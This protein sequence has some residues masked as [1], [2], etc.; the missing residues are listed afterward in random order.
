MHAKQGV[1]RGLFDTA[2]FVSLRVNHKRANVLEMLDDAQDGVAVPVSY[3]SPERGRD[4][5]PLTQEAVFAHVCL[6]AAF[7]TECRKLQTQRRTMESD[8]ND[9]QTLQVQQL[10][11]DVAANLNG[12][13]E[14]MSQQ[15][16]LIASLQASVRTMRARAI[17]SFARLCSVNRRVGWLTRPDIDP[18]WLPDFRTVAE[19]IAGGSSDALVWKNLSEPQRKR[20]ADHLGGRETFLRAA[21]EESQH[22]KKKSKPPCDEEEQQDD[23]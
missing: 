12:T 22:Q 19:R 5:P 17:Q 23:A 3:L 10:V 13:L 4:V 1:A 6:H 15:S 14:Q 20:V 2:I 9:E 11:D 18:P 16:K 7:A 8:E 21:H